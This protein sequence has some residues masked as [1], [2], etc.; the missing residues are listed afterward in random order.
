MKVKNRFVSILFGTSLRKG[1]TRVNLIH[2]QGF[3]RYQIA[4]FW[5][6][7]QIQNEIYTTKGGSFQHHL[8]IIPM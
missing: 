2:N 7:A 4:L 3:E 8:V 5:I 6:A 1:K